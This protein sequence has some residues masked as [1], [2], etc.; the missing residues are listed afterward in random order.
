VRVNLPSPRWQVH[1]LIWCV[2]AQIQ[3]L[4]NPVRQVLPLIRH[5]LLYPAH[6]SHLYPLSL[7]FSSTTLLSLLTTKLSYPSLSLYAMIMS[8]HW[9][10][11]TPH[12]TYPNNSIYQAQHW[13]NNTYTEYSIHY[14]KHPPSIV[15][16]PFFLVIAIWPLTIP[17]ASAMSPCMIDSHQP[18]RHESSKVKSPCNV[19]KIASQLTDEYSLSTRH[20]THQALPSTHRISLDRS[21][22]CVIHQQQLQSR[23][24]TPGCSGWLWRLWRNLVPSDGESDAIHCPSDGSRCIPPLWRLLYHAS[25]SCNASRCIV[26]SPLRCQTSFTLRPKCGEVY[27]PSEWHIC[28]TLRSGCSYVVAVYTT[29]GDV[30]AFLQPIATCRTLIYV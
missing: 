5:I 29:P 14:M 7:S 3:D 23:S 6:C 26:H 2:I 18:A 13:P 8:W 27:A 17:S 10:Q 24:E 11:H 15:C 28:Y 20:A 22:H 25:D 21:V 19:R 1:I 30:Y 16:L 12:T 4:P 9:V